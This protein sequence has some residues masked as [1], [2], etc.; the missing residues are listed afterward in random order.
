M[1]FDLIPNK[2]PPQDPS[3]YHEEEEEEEEVVE[4]DAMDE[5]LRPDAPLNLDSGA[6]AGSSD[7]LGLSTGIRMEGEEENERVVAEEGGSDDD[8]GEGGDGLFDDDG[9][10]DE[11]DM[12]MVD[13]QTLIT[14]GVVPAGAPFSITNGTPQAGDKRKLNE[15]DEYD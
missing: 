2:P 4:N 10:D 13:I 11:E 14:P 8:S 5:D 7:T 12:Q 3:S 15:D 1:D 6:V 9:E